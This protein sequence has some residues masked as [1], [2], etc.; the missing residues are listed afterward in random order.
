MYSIRKLIQKRVESLKMELDNLDKK[1][2]EE[3]DQIEKNWQSGFEKTREERRGLQ[4][5]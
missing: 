5:H 4:K 2:N 3:L 1:L